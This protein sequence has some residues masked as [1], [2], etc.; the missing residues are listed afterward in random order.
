MSVFNKSKVHPYDQNLLKTV[1]LN[2]N[3]QH[4]INREIMDTI[5][6]DAFLVKSFMASSSKHYV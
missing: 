2:F 5:L 4:V 3:A 1:T 6:T